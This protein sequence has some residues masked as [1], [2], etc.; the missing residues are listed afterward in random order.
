MLTRP[1]TASSRLALGSC[2]AAM[3]RIVRDAHTKLHSLRSLRLATLGNYVAALTCN[4][5]RSYSLNSYANDTLL[6]YIFRI[7]STNNSKN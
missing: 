1:I 4:S 6:E 5:L 7:I 3:L 2:E